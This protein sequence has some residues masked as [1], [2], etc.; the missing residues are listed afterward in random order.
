[1][2]FT[3]VVNNGQVASG[4]FVDGVQ[5]INSGGLGTGNFVIGDNGK[6]VVNDGGAISN[7]IVTNGGNIDIQAGATV[8]GLWINAN[9]GSAAHI[10]S[11]GTFTN[12]NFVSYRRNTSGDLGTF[13][14][15]GED[16]VID[17]GGFYGGLMQLG[18][19]SWDPAVNLAA[20][21]T[22]MN[23]TVGNSMSNSAEDSVLRWFNG[24]A[25]NITIDGGY[26][27]HGLN[28]V[29]ND[30]V[31]T[32]A[33]VKAGTLRADGYVDGLTVD[34]GYVSFCGSASQ[35]VMNGGTL[36]TTINPT[37]AGISG[38]LFTIDTLTMNGGTANFQYTTFNS[39]YIGVGAVLGGRGGDNRWGDILV[40]GGRVSPVTGNFNQVAGNITMNSGIVSAT[41]TNFLGDN[42]MYGGTWNFGNSHG[43]NWGEFGYAKSIE[44]VDGMFTYVATEA[45]F[46][47]ILGRQIDTLTIHADAS[48]QLTTKG[49][50]TRK[51]T[52]GNINANWGRSGI[53]SLTFIDKYG[54]ENEVIYD[55]NNGTSG[56][57]DFNGMVITSG[58]QL[59]INDARLVK[60]IVMDGSTVV[61]YA[62]NQD[63]YINQ[64]GQWYVD[65]GITTATT[66]VQGLTIS[67]HAGFFQTNV[68]SNSQV[69]ITDGGRYE[70]Y[71]ANYASGVVV[72]GGGYRYA[73][74]NGVLYRA[75]AKFGQTRD[76]AEL[77]IYPGS[78][79]NITL[80]NGGSAHIYNANATVNDVKI[81]AGGILYMTNWD[82]NIA[83]GSADDVKVSRGGM[84]WMHNETTA[85][86]V[87]ILAGGQMR[88]TATCSVSGS[89]GGQ[90]FSFDGGFGN[91]AG[92]TSGVYLAGNKTGMY[93]VGDDSYFMVDLNGGYVTDISA[94]SGYA[95]GTQTTSYGTSS[96]TIGGGAV[97]NYVV[98]SGSKIYINNGWGGNA[99]N[100]NNVI[101]EHGGSL[102]YMATGRPTGGF[103]TF[104]NV[105]YKDIDGSL[106]TM[107]LG[108][109][110]ASGIFVDQG[111]VF[112]VNGYSSTPADANGATA[113]DTTV[114]GGA[115]LV[116]N[117]AIATGIKM[118]NEGIAQFYGVAVVEGQNMDED[119]DSIYRKFNVESGMASG[120]ILNSGGFLRNI[121]SATNIYL[122]E[123][124]L[125]TENGHNAAGLAQFYNWNVLEF[126]EETG[127]GAS[128]IVV[129]NGHVRLL[130]KDEFALNGVTFDRDG[131][132]VAFAYD[133]VDGFGGAKLYNMGLAF[134]G[135]SANYNANA[136]LV[137]GSSTI[138]AGAT[139]Q[140]VVFESA[141]AVMNSFAGTTFINT[142]FG[143]KNGNGNAQGFSTDTNW[144]L[145]TMQ[146]TDIVASNGAVLTLNTG[147]VING[148]TLDAKGST[149]TWA[150]FYADAVVNNVKILN[151][152]NFDMMNTAASNIYIG[153][154][155]S[156]MRLRNVGAVATDVLVDKGNTHS[157][158]IDF[159]QGTINN[160]TMLGGTI[161]LQFTDIVTLDTHYMVGDW[162]FKNA[163]FNGSTFFNTINNDNLNSLTLAGN[164]SIVGDG[165]SWF[166]KGVEF[167]GANNRV[168]TGMLVNNVNVKVQDVYFNKGSQAIIANV[169][170]MVALGT[171]TLDISDCQGIFSLTAGAAFDYNTFVV[172][173]VQQGS[174]SAGQSKTINGYV[175][176]LS[177]VNN[178][179]T[180]TVRLANSGLNMDMRWQQWENDDFARYATDV[181]GT[182]TDISMDAAAIAQGGFMFTDYMWNQSTALQAINL[183]ATTIYGARSKDIYTTWIYV[184]DSQVNSIYGGNNKTIANGTNLV[185][186]N[187]NTSYLVGGN[188]AGGTI[189][190]QD[191]RNAVNLVVTGGTHARV[192]GGNFNG[193]EVFGDINLVLNGGRYTSVIIG[194]GN[195]TT[196]WG[197]VKITINGGGEN[198]ANS[199]YVWGAQNSNINGDLQMTVSGGSFVGMFSPGLRGSTAGFYEGGNVSLVINGAA[200][201]DSNPLALASKVDTAW[202]FV[203][204]FAVTGA[205]VTV[206]DISSNVANSGA[207]FK[208]L[209]GGGGAD[210][211]LSSFTGGDVNMVV[212]GVTIAGGL[213]GAGYTFNSGTVSVGDVN[214][215][216]QSGNITTTISGDILAGG[217]NLGGTGTI[218]YGSTRT[219]FSGDGSSLIFTRN[220]DGGFTGTNSA[221]LEF[222]DFSGSFNGTVSNVSDIFFSGDTTMSFTNSV[223]SDSI[224]F[225]LASRSS[226]S[227]SDMYADGALAFSSDATLGLVL[228]ISFKTD[229]FSLAL[230]EVADSSV[231]EGLTIGLTSAFGEAYYAQFDLGSGFTNEWGTVTISEDIGILFVSFTKA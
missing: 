95:M 57:L 216:I 176:S 121:T 80:R 209:V 60:N 107:T 167:L 177:L 5:T 184:E 26:F 192:Y 229:N 102:V 56:V 28:G 73:T 111:G 18:A 188:A 33:V 2:A 27:W 153:S 8:D 44:V 152:A 151:A 206:G 117:G 160:L 32:N 11:G 84:L 134:Y 217:I 119:A 69:L 210:G 93:A 159:R 203:G 204:G 91:G 45:G 48:F 225:D 66:R 131:A 227:Y 22:L 92:L 228:D 120:V 197:D 143:G 12:L 98:H 101:V 145:S 191:D 94:I 17:G 83:G 34:G 169:A 124:G 81:E 79:S 6:V 16:V 162:Y 172:N 223:V 226:S 88:L 219:T 230:M 115:M 156:F 35:V 74:S 4:E 36:E 175:Y 114:Y 185:I 52:D 180:L 61:Q 53:Q 113:V 186:N 170:D 138:T 25:M 55:D 166:D 106:K 155:L 137:G 13:L 118:Y 202:L 212:G 136:V 68:G 63:W 130:D 194:G 157:Y 179:T 128:D 7:I 187:T 132:E 208:Y 104:N 146:G 133:D 122:G 174:F 164:A 86:N 15:M 72:D 62:N 140:N 50:T 198:N 87:Q 112:C 200:S 64:T 142:T 147:G 89:M 99:V 154:G 215:R 21:G 195:N 76:G 108:M 70:L 54:V 220:V 29:R 37:D 189:T 31:L 49:M 43:A 59:R 190:V 135:A 38:G 163:S 100:V 85:T 30:A 165:F 211:A 51:Y 127:V 196:V 42:I 148:L 126:N 201:F 182:M 149:G 14:I 221:V 222:A 24:D 193:G 67:G 173:G 110:Y 103:T 78:A 46:N 178:V 158:A 144:N 231:L 205:D 181:T 105:R 39:A 41:N 77:I 125:G 3:P 82:K 23:F 1:M 96:Y 109:G 171:T 150:Q 47:V 141:A 207:S 9:T 218:S 58:S 20:S 129:K 139:V 123:M 161:S 183:Q 40:D 90:A 213:Y 71:G 19:V 199:A 75:E 10:I 214:L 116:G 97:E 168:G 65:N 224:V